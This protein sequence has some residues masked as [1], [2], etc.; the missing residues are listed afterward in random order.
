MSPLE[1]DTIPTLGD[2]IT[3]N[4]DNEDILTPLK[5]DNDNPLQKMMTRR[6]NKR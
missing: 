3:V 4:S 5:D 1:P 2:K 6:I